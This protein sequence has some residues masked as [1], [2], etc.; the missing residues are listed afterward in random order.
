MIPMATPTAASAAD[1]AGRGRGRG[2][3]VARST[4]AGASSSPTSPHRLQE[5]IAESRQGLDVAGRLRVVIQSP[6]DASDA[7][8]HALVELDVNLVGPEV[9]PDSL[10][11]HEGAPAGGQQAKQL[12]R[13]GLQPNRFLVAVRFEC[14]GIELELAEAQAARPLVADAAEPAGTRRL[15]LRCA[16]TGL[17]ELHLHCCARRALPVPELGSE[18]PRDRTGSSRTRNK[19][20]PWSVRDDA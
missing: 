4:W 19:T 14:L 18:S 17:H 20:I 10:A 8:V 3:H 12:G 2:S 15:A 13:L 11:R 16:V 7:R 5:S 6:P 1:G 9:A